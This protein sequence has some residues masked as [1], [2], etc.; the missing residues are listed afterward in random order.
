M[1]SRLSW[2]RRPLSLAVPQ[3]E[4]KESHQRK[5]HG[6]GTRGRGARGGRERLS[7]RLRQILVSR[8]QATV[9]RRTHYSDKLHGDCSAGAEHEGELGNAA[10][11]TNAVVSEENE[12]GSDDALVRTSIQQDNAAAKLAAA[13]TTGTRPDDKLLGKTPHVELLGNV[14]RTATL[15]NVCCTSANAG[16]QWR[17]TGQINQRTRQPWDKA[18]SRVLE[19]TATAVQLAKDANVGKDKHGQ[20]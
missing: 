17:A 13:H 8:S 14:Q 16:K 5:G 1:H 11:D 4:E 6:Q 9:R 15:R 18:G 2:T 7:R 12:G 10:M 19:N 3:F 20:N